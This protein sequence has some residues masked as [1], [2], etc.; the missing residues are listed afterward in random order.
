MDKITPYKPKNKGGSGT[1]AS[2]FDGHD[3]KFELRG[4]VLSGV[5]GLEFKEGVKK[6]Q[7]VKGF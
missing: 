1:A 2:L 7:V 3:A 6:N 5:L 4:I